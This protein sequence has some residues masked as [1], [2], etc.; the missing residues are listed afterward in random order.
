MPMSY[1]HLLCLS[2]PKPSN[3][4]MENLC[5]FLWRENSLIEECLVHFSNLKTVYCRNWYSPDVSLYFFCCITAVGVTW[6]CSFLDFHR[7]ANT[8][9]N[10]SAIVPSDGITVGVCGD[11]GYWVECESDSDGLLQ[12]PS[13]MIGHCQCLYSDQLKWTHHYASNF[14]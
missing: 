9:Q 4:G 7:F 1:V 6:S 12:V 2:V 14:I 3:F 11:S 8:A 5:W 10:T 13:V